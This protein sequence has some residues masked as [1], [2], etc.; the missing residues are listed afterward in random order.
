[1]GEF[2]DKGLSLC[3]WTVMRHSPFKHR[4]TKNHRRVWAG[5]DLWR[6]SSPTPIPKQVHL[7]QA[8]QDLI[9]VILNISRE[10]DSI[11]PDRWFYLPPC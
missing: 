4:I 2:F 6:S 7:D 10:G 9:H 11:T 8:T 1:M 5:R 3:T